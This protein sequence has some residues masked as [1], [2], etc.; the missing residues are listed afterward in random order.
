MGASILYERQEPQTRGWE[1]TGKIQ[2][3]ASSN[4]ANVMNR[5]RDGYASY[6]LR[7][8]HNS[9]MKSLRNS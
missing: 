3:T 7:G 1:K 6:P 4:A 9:T 2:V 8:T 5:K